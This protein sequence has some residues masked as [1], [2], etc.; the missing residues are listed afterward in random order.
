MKIKLEEIVQN[1]KKIVGLLEVKFPI[2]VSYRIK[3]LVDKLVPILKTYHNKRDEIIKEL[4]T[5]DKDDENYSVKEPE[6][7]K[8]FFARMK[9]LEGVEEEISFEPIKISELGDVAFSPKE[10]PS[11]IFE[12]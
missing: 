12:E 11:F 9:E 4:G 1:E 2:K 3:R 8:E 5:K 6:K 7:V 10:I